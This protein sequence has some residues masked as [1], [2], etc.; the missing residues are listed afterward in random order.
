MDICNKLVFRKH[1]MKKYI[2]IFCKSKLRINNMTLLALI[3]CIEYLLAEILELSEICAKEHKKHT[4]RVHDIN[5]A[6]YNDKKHVG[7]FNKYILPND[8]ASDIK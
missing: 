2:K 8:L 4:I 5:Y 1:I 7:M 3:A 6:I